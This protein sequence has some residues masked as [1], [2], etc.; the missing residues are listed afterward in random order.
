MTKTST[1]LLK[2]LNKLIV[3]FSTEN[4]LLKK[5]LKKSSLIENIGR[6]GTKIKFALKWLKVLNSVLNLVVSD[7]HSKI[8]T[9]TISKKS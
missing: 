9:L 4:F 5:P 6:V 2:G 3:N 8:A 1:K 7:C